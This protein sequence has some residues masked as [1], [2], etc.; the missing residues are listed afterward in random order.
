K[1]AP[2]K[3]PPQQNNGPVT[4]PAGS[5]PVNDFD[6]DYDSNQ[7]T[8]YYI[9]SP[10]S[11]YP[12][13]PDHGN[14]N[15]HDENGAGAWNPWSQWGGGFPSYG[16]PY[17]NYGGNEGW[18]APQNKPKKPQQQKPHQPPPGLQLQLALAQS[19]LPQC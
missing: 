3:T 16:N 11:W 5:A 1:P 10:Y 15:G 12:P 18:G 8:N 6:V 13:T 4:P 2:P 19:L 9:N 7:Y 17:Q 14:E